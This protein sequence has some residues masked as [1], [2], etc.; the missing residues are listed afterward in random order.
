[1]ADRPSIL[2]RLARNNRGL[3]VLALAIAVVSWYAVRRATSY[4]TVI[5]DVPFTVAVGE[6]WS[7]LDRSIA[8]VDVIFSGTLQDL[9][10]LNREQIKIEI[11]AHDVEGSGTREFRI[12]AGEVSHPGGARVLHVEP[13]LVRL[14]LDREEAKMLPVRA[15]LVGS[16]PE[17]IE[18]AKV[19]CTP[20][21]AMIRGPRQRLEEVQMLRSAPIDLEGRMRSFEVTR[22][23]SDPSG[24][25]SARLDPAEVRVAVTLIERRASRSIPQVRVRTLTGPGE[26]SGVFLQPPEVTV[27]LEGDAA[28]L[29]QVSAEQ[30]VAF[31]DSSAAV[32]GVVTNLGVRVSPPV[33]LRAVGVEPAQVRALRA[34]GSAP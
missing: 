9:Q 15:D 12:T 6:G 28:A 30:V 5:K 3:K 23:L 11:D 14:T 4:E 2:L 33:G 34:A 26:S 22:P 27:R 31:V 24:M 16:P 1:M 8:D 19:E 21:S 18:V 10:F 13:D 17:G 20:A 7:V 29:Q 32:P 25:W